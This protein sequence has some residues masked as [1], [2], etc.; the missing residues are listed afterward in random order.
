MP[1][2][3]PP[4]VLCFGV[5]D[6]TGGAGL[7]ADI[8]TLASLGCHPAAVTTAVT[9]QDTTGVKQYVPMPSEIVIAQARAVLEDM[10]VAAFK[11]G[12]LGSI[13]TV[14]AIAGVI[15][16]YPQVPLVVDPVQTSG[17]GDALSDEP[18]DEALRV[19]LLPRTTLIT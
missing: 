2:P 17:H 14:T 16:D 15:R 3:V 8:L 10:P 7:S 18:L 13:A 4:V 12:M 11:T 1:N 9:A 6:A 19:L 5:T